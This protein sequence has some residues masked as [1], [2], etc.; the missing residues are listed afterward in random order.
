LKRKVLVFVVCYNAESFI[1]KVLERI[2]EDVRSNP[3]YDLE[4]LVI[5]DQSSDET[6]H[7]AE[8]WARE[9]SSLPITVLHN[10]RNQG[11]GGN[12]KIGYHY[13]VRNGFDVVVLL[14]GDGQYA[15]EYLGKMVEPILAGEADAVLGSRML[16]KRTALAGGMPL[17]KWIGNQILTALQNR[18]LGSRLAEF[19]TG[20][21]AYSVPVLASL[22]FDYDSN[23]F[24]FDTDILIQ[25]ID[26]K[27]RIREIPIP[28]FYG[29][30]IS[31]VNGFRYA[32]LILVSSALS[33]VT[34]WGVFYHP[35]FD[36]AAKNEF[37]SLKLGYESSHQFALDRV[38]EGATA[39]DLGCGPGLVAREL[40]ARGVRTVSVDRHISELAKQSS[41]KTV[42][43]DVDSHDFSTDDDFDVILALDII[44]HLRSP[45]RFLTA[46]RERHC[47]ETPKVIL[48]TGN[49]AF[50][51][52]RIALLL[53]QFNYGKR[54]IL[55]L[56]HSRLFTFGS[57]RR[58]LDHMGFEIVE[59]RGI[60]APFPEA[61]GRGPLASFL[62]AANAFL[63]R[64]SR[65][66]FSY[67]IAIVAKP[68]PT[69]DR[70]LADAYASAAEKVAEPRSAAH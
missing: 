68:K 6:F 9:H 20:Y 66:L 50:L 29:D 60:P 16:T 44:E 38:P 27:A 10:P 56:T 57:L 7:R 22:P 23:Y 59:E 39:L 43:A 55:D 70:L 30:E 15:P 4:V 3:A 2:P 34:K 45:E 53:G 61:V 8:A 65:S 40:S 28:T 58:L 13:A 14:H 17:Y 64:I 25:L 48:T 36:Y 51:P 26:N 35:K 12:Q 24:D 54:G 47:R 69:L 11:Y 32:F 67:Q 18:L 21:R 52:I 63:I 1:E 42:E 41:W 19:H 5:D 37:Y 31:R 46:M 33:R 49:V 62:L